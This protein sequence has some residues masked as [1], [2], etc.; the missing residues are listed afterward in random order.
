MSNESEPGVELSQGERGW[1]QRFRKNLPFIVFIAVLAIYTSYLQLT[2]RDSLLQLFLVRNFFQVV[3]A[4]LVIATMKNVFGL[5]TLG[6]FGPAIVALAFLST[7]LL[8]GLGLFGLILVAVFATR[9]ALA[10]QHVQGAH[11]AAILV[12]MIGVIISTVTL[13]GLQFEQHELFYAVLFPVLI[14]AWMG[15][16]YV[17]ETV[18]VGWGPPTVD[19]AGTI[20]AIVVS[21]VVITQDWLVDFVMANPTSW[22]AFVVIYLFLGTRI[23]LRIGEYFRFW[24]PIHYGGD[25]PGPGD[26]RG[27]I[28]TMVVR[29]RDFVAKYNPTGVMA[30]AG[31]DAVRKLLQPYGIPVAQTYLTINRQGEM[32]SFRDWMSIHNTFAIKPDRGYGGGGILLLQKGGWD[33]GYYKNIGVLD[34]PPLECPFRP[35]LD[36][37]DHLDGGA[38]RLGGLVAQ[39]SSLRKIAPVGLA[40]FRIISFLGYPVMAMMR[41]PTSSSGGKANLHSGAVAAGVQIS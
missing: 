18:R 4:A 37:E 38:W 6:T 14:S 12:S 19:L 5:R 41:I 31:K 35:P 13:I 32:D 33:G 23:R 1:K 40:D 30:R 20:V 22:V 10:Q 25:G 7:G 16:S 17:E 34:V 8:L 9:A 28:L 26:Y 39:D 27:D 24:G 29:N 36:G 11:R 21:F 2:M 15:E 3:I